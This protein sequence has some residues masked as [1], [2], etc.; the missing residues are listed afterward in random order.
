MTAMITTE[1]AAATAVAGAAVARDA[2]R[3]Q[4]IAAAVR[5]FWLA[6]AAPESA[7]FLRL[8]LGGLALMQLVILWPHLLALYGNY[9]FVQ[10]AVLEAGN[11]AWV[12]SI[13]KLAM[14]LADWDIS[15]ATTVYVVF[16]LYGASLV[17]VVVGYRTRLFSVLALLGHTVTLNS[18]FFSLYGVDTMMHILFFYLALS[19]AGS[20]WSLDAYLGRAS[21]APNSAARIAQRMLQLHLCIVY[22]NTGMAK[23]GG[24]QWWNGEAIWRAVMQ[25]QF[26]VFDFT[27]LTE[28][29]MVAAALGVSVIAIEIGYSVLIWIPKTRRLVLLAAIGMHIGIAVTMRLWLFSAMMIAFNLAAFGWSLPARRDRTASLVDATRAAP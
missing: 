14:V 7:A 15:A 16:A 6:P 21:P 12:P 28:M 10:W 24:E 18:G 22:L 25:P 3:R 27:W 1:A 8:A 9:G 26:N 17:G 23:A 29:P 19:P 2:T 13:G 11:N 5:T 20:T 4:R